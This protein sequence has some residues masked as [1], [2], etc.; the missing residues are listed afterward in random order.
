MI[1]S[2]LLR[3]AVRA[4]GFKFKRQAKHTYLYRKGR[5]IIHVRRGQIDP[6]EARHVLHAAGYADAETE[7]FLA[8][9]APQ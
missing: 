3:D 9:H 4:K 5:D 6:K 7:A 8:K 1:A 2:K